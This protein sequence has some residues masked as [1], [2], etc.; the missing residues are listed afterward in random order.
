[1]ASIQK[2]PEG[3]WRARYRDLDGQ[4]HARHFDRKTDAQRWL[5]EVTA[6]MVTG[7]YVDPRAGRITFRARAEE[8][9]LSAP[10]GPSMQDKVRR[11]LER[12]A[13]PTFGDSP[14]GSIRPSAV[15]GWVTGLRLSPASAKVTLGYVS[16][17]FRA[18]VRDR[19]IMSNPA[20]EVRPPAA[21]P[22]EVFIPD[23]DVVK[24]VRAALPARYRAAVDLVLGSGLRAGEVFGLEVDSIEFLRGRSVIVRQQLVSLSPEPQ[25]LG[26]PKSAESARTV[27]LAETT[28]NAMAAHLAAF[29]ARE[30]VMS[31]RTDRQKPRDRAVHLV[32]TTDA[33]SP[34]SRS[35]WSQI[36]RPAARAAGIPERVGLHAVRHFYASALIRHGESVKVVQ[37]RLGHSSAAVTLDTYAHLWPDSDDRT[38]DAVEAALNADAD[39]ARTG[40]AADGL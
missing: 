17:V 5:D 22:V 34:V 37:K 35:M 16:A 7:Q 30:V 25:H 33:G 13:Y 9:R 11:A 38:R 14:I 15:Q 3:K 28:L 8:W 26:L 32:F 12:H 23:L 29:P 20:Q 4:E 1:M 19:V 39:S 31:D 18:S 10:H 27:P 2:R 6:A 21:R 36:W 24:R 40:E